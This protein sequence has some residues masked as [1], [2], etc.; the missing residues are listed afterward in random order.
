MSITLVVPSSLIGCRPGLVPWFEFWK[1]DTDYFRFTSLP[2]LQSIATRNW[3]QPT[4]C[5]RRG[6]RPEE[7]CQVRARLRGFPSTH[8]SDPGVTLPL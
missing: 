6:L 3:L 8:V 7:D 4:V 2:G 5:D 1:T